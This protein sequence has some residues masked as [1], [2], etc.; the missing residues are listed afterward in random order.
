VHA[1]VLGRKAQVVALAHRRA[2]ARTQPD[3]AHL[4]RAAHAAL[5]RRARDLDRLSLA[6]VAHDPERTLERGYALV[7]SRS[8][9]LLTTAA[10]ARA[11]G[12]LG[13]RFADGRVDAD[14]REE[15]EG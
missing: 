10:A 2:R 4:R 7:E 6:L 15:G 9:D 12:R 1:L 11:S 5:A 3:A 14:V 8:G 13:L